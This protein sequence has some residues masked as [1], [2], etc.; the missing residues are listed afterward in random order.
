M[1]SIWWQ[2]YTKRWHLGFKTS[3]TWKIVCIKKEG[4]VWATWNHPPIF[5]FSVLLQFAV[6]GW[7]LHGFS[8]SW[9][10]LFG[11]EPRKGQA[12]NSKS[13]S[14]TQISAIPDKTFQLKSLLARRRASHFSDQQFRLSAIIVNHKIYLVDAHF[15]YQP[16]PH[17]RRERERVTLVADLKKICFSPSPCPPQRPSQGFFICLFVYSSCPFL[18]EWVSNWVG[19]I[20]R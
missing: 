17:P 11:V 20:N 19:W 10:I 18:G 13:W 16:S 1:T 7:L 12:G 9:S 15:L 3:R 4:L 8:L 2:E 5:W 14:I 6:E